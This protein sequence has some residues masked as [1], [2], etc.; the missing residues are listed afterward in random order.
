MLSSYFDFFSSLSCNI[1]SEEI[2][3][4]WPFAV[5]YSG[6]RF[7]SYSIHKYRLWKDLYA[8]LSIGYYFVSGLVNIC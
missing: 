5:K 2:K 6:E 8:S 4:K 3:G 7:D 1:Q